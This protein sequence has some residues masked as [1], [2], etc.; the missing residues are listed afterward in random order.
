VNLNP[1]QCYQALLTRDARFDGRFFVA[2]KTTHIYCR[3]IC[4]VKTPLRKNCQF[5]SHAAAAEAAGYRPCK[6]CRPELAPGN[7]PM[8]VSSQ[9]ARSTA[10]QIGQ[11]FL[12]EHSLAE[13]AEK[14][15]VTDRQMRRVFHDEFGVSP[16]E[17]WQTQ[18]LLLAKQLLTDSS[19]PVTSVALASG[20]RSLRRFNALLKQRYRMTPT[21]LR[22]NQQRPVSEN[23]S[24][25]SF[26][27]SYRPPFDWDRLLGFLSLRAIPHV[28][29]VHDGSYFHTVHVERKDRKFTGSIEVRN[30]AAQNMLSVRLSD[31]LLPVCAVVLERVKRLFDLHA[32]P[33]AIDKALGS[34][35]AKRPGLRLPGSFDGFEM[36]VRAILGQQI[37]VAGARTLAGR[38]ALRFGAP[39]RT[40]LPSLTHLFPSS[41]R[42][43]TTTVNEIAKLGIIGQRA[44]TLIALAKA[45]ARGELLLE[46]GRRIETTLGQL[47]KI[48]GIGE[49]TAQYIA[50]RALSWP[51]AFPHTDLGIRKALAENNPARILALAEKMAPLAGLRDSSP[52]DQ[53]DRKTKMTYSYKTT[54]SPVGYLKLVATDKGLAAVLW[55]NENPTRVPLSP[56]IDNKTHPVLLETERQ[57]QEYFAGKRTSFSIKLDPVGTEFQNK[58]WRALSEIPFGETRS[59]GQ[60]A[61]RI[62]NANAMRAVGAAN[63]KNPISIIVPC[64]RVIGAS[65]KLTGFAGG[66]KIKA[67]LLALETNTGLIPSP[68]FKH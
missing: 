9:L 20:F 58:V 65:G 5:L 43:A 28:E 10:Y 6:R 41:Q 39:L 16:V 21:E 27:L 35:A 63:G 52:L 11:D 64:H 66:L 60:I 7:S 30:E 44:K 57:L 25:F 47:R 50:M 67:Q 2:V 37:S 62:G 4:R 18:R 31:A 22:K 51:D 3:P 59:Y 1:D 13:L 61:K 36:A 49:W 38:L 12:A 33:T 68:A 32:D 23:F 17:F 29:T 24:E 56:L 54:K 42:I 53:P 8:E 15:G 34:L 14:L 19:M 40:S 48:P 45:V 55:E 26:R 46:P